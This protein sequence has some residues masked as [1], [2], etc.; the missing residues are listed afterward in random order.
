M[1]K[2]TLYVYFLFLG[3]LLSQQPVN[4]G[5]TTLLFT[6]YTADDVHVTATGDYCISSISPK[7]FHLSIGENRNV[8]INYKSGV[9]TYCGWRHSHQYFEITRSDHSLT[10]TA[11]IQW[12][13]E[14][15][16]ADSIYTTKD[17]ANIIYINYGDPKQVII[18][19]N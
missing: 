6:N 3:F 18:G 19:F 9:F 2:R 1:M 7:D 10:Q 15:G 11:E 4:A 13:K 8:T 16:G 5:S 12:Y 14:T 17:A